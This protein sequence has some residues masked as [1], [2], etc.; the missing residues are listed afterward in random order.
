MST[1][2]SVNDLDADFVYAF[3]GG[4]VTDTVERLRC[5]GGQLENS[6]DF[7]LMRL[8]TEAADE[9]ERLR[10]ENKR[11][12]DHWIWKEHSEQRSEI[13][14]L[15]ADLIGTEQQMNDT[16][17]GNAKKQEEIERL[18][19]RDIQATR[20]VLSQREEIGRLREELERHV[21][22][23]RAALQEDEEPSGDDYADRAEWKSRL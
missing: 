17:L 19:E 4:N 2:N 13:E 9:I 22:H 3:N 21:I 23:A 1:R 8:L 11:L 5:K 6:D 20:I 10:G 12:N 18:R 7:D 14:R 16:A 15:R